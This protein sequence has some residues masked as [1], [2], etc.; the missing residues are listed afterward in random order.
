MREMIVRM[1]KGENRKLPE[2]WNEMYQ[3]HVAEYKQMHKDFIHYN[4]QMERKACGC[5]Q[6]EEKYFLSEVQTEKKIIQEFKIE[7]VQLER[8]VA[9]LKENV[10]IKEQERD[11]IISDYQKA[12]KEYETTVPEQR[13]SQLIK[14]KKRLEGNRKIIL[15]T[16]FTFNEI[17][18]S[19]KVIKKRIA[20]SVKDIDR[21]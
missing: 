14:L 8:N 19:C 20:K 18:E 3:T 17:N 6:S 12:L 21:V 2:H 11:R 7:L 5:S 4:T 1:G 15:D 13:E 10:Q 9:K 16:K